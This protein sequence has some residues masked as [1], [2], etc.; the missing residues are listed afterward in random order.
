MGADVRDAL[1]EHLA[2]AS[3]GGLHDDALLDVARLCEEVGRVVDA[4]RVTIAGEL[5]HR[6]RAELGSER[7][8]ATHGCRTAAELLERVGLVSAHTARTRLRAAVPL[9]GRTSLTGNRLPAP[10]A[11][12]A[13]ALAAGS[14]GIDAAAAIT[15]VLNPSA[16]RCMP[17][18]LAAAER[19]LV[20]AAIGDI[21]SPPHTPDDVR[22]MAQTWVLVLDPDGVLPDEERALRRRGLTFGRE[23][24]G[25]VAVRGELLLEV[26]AQWQRLNDAYL[27]PRI[28]TCSLPTFAP[29]DGRDTPSDTASHDTRSRAQRLHDALGGILSVA[30]KS[31]DTPTLGG[32]APTL[33]VT[34]SASDLENAHGVGFIEG[35]DT[36]VSAT[37]AR[38]MACTGA[39][40][41]ITVDAHGRVLELCSP[42][43]SFTTHQRR[44]IAQRDGGC[45]IPGCH[46]GATWCEIHH[47]TEHARGGP[48]HT[49]NGVLLCWFHHR[50][51]ETSGWAVTMLDGV[52]HIKAP[53]WIDPSFRWRPASGSLHRRRDAR[54]RQLHAE[55][56]PSG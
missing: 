45:I 22:L 44:A 14:I 54:L 2:V 7:L 34:I 25:T 16:D 51:L 24:A 49:D 29:S 12:V 42:L 17:D 40:Q 19:E 47:V 28:D 13:A 27:N 39:I 26:A 8:S 41:R 55:N 23:R 32:S 15:D 43:R 10:F 9:R 36:V 48:T 37:F 6:S 31:A 11:E 38:T 21:V 3:L 30:A 46:V 1:C 4:A 33:V 35:T 56:L 5:G 20:A 53:P 18:D 50:T 52:P